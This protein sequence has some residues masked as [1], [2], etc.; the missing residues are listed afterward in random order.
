M[1]QFYDKM[2]PKRSEIYKNAQFIICSECKTMKSGM[3]FYIMYKM[4]EAFEQLFGK[5]IIQ[6]VHFACCDNC[7]GTQFAIRIKEYLRDEKTKTKQ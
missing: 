5:E 3:E 6:D 2:K 4:G 1:P 7:C